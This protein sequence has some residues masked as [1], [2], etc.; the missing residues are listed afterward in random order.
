MG[1]EASNFDEDALGK[2]NVSLAL[3]EGAVKKTSDR[4]L[5]YVFIGDDLLAQQNELIEEG[6]GVVRYLNPETTPTSK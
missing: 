2:G 6:L 5:A 1:K 3:D 4:Y